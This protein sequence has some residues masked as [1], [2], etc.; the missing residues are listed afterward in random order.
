ME[1]GHEDEPAFKY[2]LNDFKEV[3]INYIHRKTSDVERL[4]KQKKDAEADQ[5]QK[6]IDKQ[7]NVFLTDV[8][9]AHCQIIENTLE[10]TENRAQ[11]QV[12]KSASQIYNKPLFQ[13]NQDGA[14]LYYADGSLYAK[15]PDE[16]KQEYY[17]PDGTLKR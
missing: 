10:E 11:G 16:G 2:L 17:Y 15:L 8:A 6:Q 12:V 13:R 4:K 14:T 9:T 3:Y 5:L 7:V 1:E